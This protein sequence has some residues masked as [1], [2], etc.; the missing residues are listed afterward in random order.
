[1]AVASSETS[2]LKIFHGAQATEAGV[3]AELDALLE[4]GAE[5][6][7]PQISLTEPVRVVVPSRSLRDHLAR[8]YLQHRGRPVLG[9]SFQTLQGLAMEVL[10]G[11]GEESPRGGALFPLLVERFAREEAELRRQLD[12]LVD[13]YLPVAGTVRDLVDAGLEPEHR[14]GAL[15]A[16]VGR[17]GTDGARVSRAAEDRAKALL[18]VGD[19]V[20]RAM[21]VMGVG[22]PS[23]ALARARTLIE[24]NAE[25]AL[26][27]RAVLVHGFADATGR[28]ADLLEAL[29]QHCGARIFLDHPPKPH[30]E[31]ALTVEDGRVRGDEVETSF[32]QRLRERLESAGAAVEV[33]PI[34][35]LQDTRFRLLETSDPEAEVQAAAGWVRSHLGKGTPPEDLALVARDLGTYESSIW[36]CFRRLGIPFSFW[37]DHGSATEAGRGAEGV[38]DLLRL[39]ERTPVDR[40]LQVARWS[41]WEETGGEDGIG[42]EQT[43]G[44]QAARRVELRLALHSLGIG[45]LEEMKRLDLA[46]I[47]KR[48]GVN[49][50]NLQAKAESESGDEPEAELEFETGEQ[51]PSS[52]PQRRL[53][54]VERLEQAVESASALLELLEQWPESAPLS[55]HL[56]CFQKLLQGGLGWTGTS[57]DR[58]LVTGLETQLEAQRQ[59]L[60]EFGALEI[61]QSELHRLLAGILKTAGRSCLGGKG[62]GVQ[63]L[64]VTE[65]R[66]RT[67]GQLLILGMNRG[68]MPRPVR[69]DPLLPDTLRRRLSDVLPDIPLKSRGFDEERYLFAQLASSAE[70]VTLARHESDHDGRPVPPSPLLAR[71]QARSSGGAPSSG[72]TRS[73]A[74]TQPSERVV[75]IVAEEASPLPAED[76][77][78]AAG[79]AGYRAQALELLEVVAE[80]SRQGAELE[81]FSAETWSRSL[82]AVLDELDPDLRTTEGRL[83]RASLGPFLGLVGP[84]EGRS[85]AVDPRAGRVWV[86]H[87]EG[88]ASCPWQTFLRR[89]LK[90]EPSPDPLQALPD[91]SP[92]LLGQVVHGMVERI[93]VDRLGSKRRELV[94]LRGQAPKSVSWPDP[95]AFEVLL[96]Q[97]VDETLAKEGIFLSLLAE[98]LKEQARSLLE[99]VR[100]QLWAT[101]GGLLRAYGAEV[102]GEADVGA[103]SEDGP[104]RTVAFRADLAV[105]AGDE[106][107]PGPL[108]LL[109]LKT[110]RSPISSAKGEGTRRKHLL[111]QIRRGGKLQGAAYALA[112][113]TA[114]GEYVFVHPDLRGEFR[115]FSVEEEDGDAAAAFT[116]AAG[117]AL[118]GWEEGVF[119]PRLVDPRGQK[120][121]DRCKTC[122]VAEACLRGDSGIRGRL[123]EVSEALVAREAAEKPLGE[124]ERTFLELWRLPEAEP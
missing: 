9:L 91:L 66:G 74:G 93:V 3:L 97:E 95:L 15:E 41:S 101:Q 42:C 88:I 111:Q 57:P 26:P 11:A 122:E 4:Y 79:L 19:A 18:R 47:R 20:V 32:P 67:F 73:S 50:P 121:P 12:P 46:P 10:Q 65:A 62:G 54:P 37:G 92:L 77:A 7:G 82:R 56:D 75:R 87:L 68:Q 94:D 106:E 16:L 25:A 107:N 118:D 110:G 114:A 86:T 63:I 83:R 120:E 27:A 17:K 30:S 115:A 36:R 81:G 99:Q 24:T 64:S 31:A 29:V 80:E 105:A 112:Q 58:A 90:V 43:P 78:L 96:S 33:A 2:F 103:S 6:L 48:G 49:L 14:E 100:E 60:R 55:K 39:G 69:E 23:N 84:V 38:L 98:P 40:W 22:R 76:H 13:G 71:L 70:S 116:A 117:T 113:D 8:R 102:R 45:R 35:T 44:R 51:E 109:D 124:E 59:Q 52:R 21:A 1:M 5:D 85:E 53:L 34:Q 108:R 119:F 89:L 61:N 104:S 123:V 28:V 72:G